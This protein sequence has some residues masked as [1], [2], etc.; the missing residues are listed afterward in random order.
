MDRTNID[1]AD[2]RRQRVAR[3]VAIGWRERMAVCALIVGIA[4]A[5]GVQL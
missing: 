5:G 1:Y 4:I 2:Q 3:G